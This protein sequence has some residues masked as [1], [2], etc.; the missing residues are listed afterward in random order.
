M[1]VSDYAALVGDFSFFFDRTSKIVEVL[2][3]RKVGCDVYSRS[4]RDHIYSN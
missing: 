2:V 4:S 3:M 1:I